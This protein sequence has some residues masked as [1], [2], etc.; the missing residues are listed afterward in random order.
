M[1]LIADGEAPGMAASPVTSPF[2][3]SLPGKLLWRDWRFLTLTAGM[4]LGLFA[5]I[6]LLAHLS[7][8]SFPPSERNWPASRLE[9]RPYPLSQ[10]AR[11]SDG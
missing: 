8:S 5:Q 1:G 9:R 6:G 11:C 3:K 7:R 10:G 4:A 2:A